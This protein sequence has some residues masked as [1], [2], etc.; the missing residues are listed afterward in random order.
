MNRQIKGRRDGIAI[1]MKKGITEPGRRKGRRKRTF[2]FGGSD[3]M[4]SKGESTVDGEVGRERGSGAKKMERGYTRGK[5][6]RG[7]VM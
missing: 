4:T 1:R 5:L 3:N 2:A 7:G 6:K